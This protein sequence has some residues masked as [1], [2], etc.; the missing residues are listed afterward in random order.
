[1][2][3]LAVQP[4]LPQELQTTCLIKLVQGDHDAQI[5]FHGCIV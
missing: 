2:A 4:E 1:M 3:A 5:S